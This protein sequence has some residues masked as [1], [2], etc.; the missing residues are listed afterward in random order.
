MAD[1]TDE[2]L[3]A[4]PAEDAPGPSRRAVL[5]C[6]AALAG[7]C[8]AMI[9]VPVGALFSAP[10]LQS[11][12]GEETWVPVGQADE[13]ASGR[14]ER[15]YTFKHQDGWHEAMV[16]KRVVVGKEGEE[17]LVL[18]TRCTH[19]GCG[20]S[21]EPEADGG[22][23]FYCPCHAGVFDPSGKPVSGPPSR[24]LDRLEAKVLDGVLMV[25]ES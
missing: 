11:G 19:L 17:W 7:A 9:M 10:V 2:T 4:Q 25:K 15:E 22:A 20:V 23:R 24:P 3:G 18:S 1:R 8:A 13:F 16:T 12:T 14:A 6:T 21:W 5:A